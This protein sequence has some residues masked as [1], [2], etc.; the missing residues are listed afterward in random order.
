M[1]G[2]RRQTGWNPKPAR[3]SMLTE[4]CILST[5]ISNFKDLLAQLQS[6]NSRSYPWRPF[7]LIINLNVAAAHHC[8]MHNLFTS[9][10]YGV[11]RPN[12]ANIPAWQLAN[13][14]A[15][16]AESNL[17]ARVYSQSGLLINWLINVKPMIGSDTLRRA[18]V[19]LWL[20][21]PSGVSQPVRLSVGIKRSEASVNDGPN[22]YIRTAELRWRRGRW[23]GD[24]C[25][26]LSKIG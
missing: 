2:V 13:D 24:V 17:T 16:I 18:R 25:S 22:R 10:S 11:T 7:R 3:L 9:S 6:V 1:S 5:R 12:A 20:E 14:S 21:T 19:T 4:M 15:L 8:F 23:G 26:F